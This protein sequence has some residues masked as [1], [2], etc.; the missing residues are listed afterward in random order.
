VVLNLAINSTKFVQKGF[1]RLRAEIVEKH[2][3]ISVEDSGPGI[4]MEKREEV[5][6][7]FQ[8]SLDVLSQG[9]TGLGLS[10]CY[11]LAETMG[12]KLSMDDSYDSGIEGFPGYDLYYSLTLRPKPQDIFKKTLP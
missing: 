12:G 11:S 4:P 9:T 7:R 6:K 2:L 5:F 3:R 8:T 10:L 1:I